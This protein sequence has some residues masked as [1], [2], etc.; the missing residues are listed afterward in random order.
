MPDFQ[1]TL[2]EHHAGVASFIATARA[3]TAAD[4]T[5][6]RAPGKWSPAQVAEHVA[7]AYE[8]SSAALRGKYPGA[9]APRLLRPL[10]RTLFLKPVLRNGRFG[11]GAKAPGPFQPT[12]SPAPASM[13]LPRVQSAADEFES[14][15]AAELAQGHVTVDHPFFGPVALGDYLRLQVIHTDHHRR[16]LPGAAAG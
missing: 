2:T 1:N 13:L 16:Q 5:Q 9:S 3:L 6:A 15:L 7:M 10:I 12:A 8:C 11:A 4:W 14:M